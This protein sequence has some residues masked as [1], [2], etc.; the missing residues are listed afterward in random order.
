MV[1]RWGLGFMINTEEASTGRAAHSMAWAG[2]ANS[3]YWL[4]PSRHLA[5][6]LLTQ[7]LP[8]ADEQVLRLFDRFETAVYGQHG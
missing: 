6:V 2:L 5:G 3:Y 4:D 1:K 7:V 8:F